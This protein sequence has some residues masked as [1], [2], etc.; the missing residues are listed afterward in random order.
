MTTEEKLNH[1]RKNALEAATKQA[2]QDVEHYQVAL[3]QIFAQHKEDKLSE[4]KQLVAD[5]Q[6]K[7]ARETNRLLTAQQSEIRKK[8]SDQTMR[9]RN[10][11]FDH[12]R[13]KL[14]DFKKSPEYLSYLCDQIR[15]IQTN[16]S[17]RS[18]KEIQF[19]VDSSDQ[20]LIRPVSE[21]TGV[22]IDI[23]KEEILGGLQAFVSDPD[24][25]I[26]NSFT[27]MLDKEK[28]AFSVEGGMRDE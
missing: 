23:S 3:D 22:K 14:V 20:N 5:E 27:A 25:M 2:D 21:K 9:I 10:Q 11:I 1:F 16:L 6:A 28:K 19:L 12:V 13:Q 18:K 24:I 17:G 26:D 7:C 4:A 15:E 8:F